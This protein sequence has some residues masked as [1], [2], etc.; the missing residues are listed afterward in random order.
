VPEVEKGIEG[1]MNFPGLPGLMSCIEE[2]KRKHPKLFRSHY[3]FFVDTIR[4]IDALTSIDIEPKQT[5]IIKT[6]NKYSKATRSNYRSFIVI[7][8]NLYQANIR[9]FKGYN[10]LLNYGYHIVY[11][12]VN[13]CFITENGAFLFV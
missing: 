3:M 12:E 13:R 4:S 8:I 11:D 9:V 10:K 7:A 5:L 1:G 6:R 2:F